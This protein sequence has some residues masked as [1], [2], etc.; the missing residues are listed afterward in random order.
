[1]KLFSLF[2]ARRYKPSWVYR[3]SG[4]LWRVLFSHGVHIA[5]EHRENEQKRVTF[6]C[7]DSR[8]GE[9]KW[10]MSREGEGWWTTTEGVY[11][12]LLYLHA[13][14]KP[15]LPH[16]KHITAVDLETGRILWEHPELTFVYATD[17]SVVAEHRSMEHTRCYRIDAESGEILETLTDRNAVEQGKTRARLNDPHTKL[18]FPERYDHG[19]DDHRVYRAYLQSLREK[20]SL[21]DPVEVFSWGNNLIF[22]YHQ[23]QGENAGGTAPLSHR[24]SIIHRSDNTLLYR[25]TILENA[26]AP[27]PD[28]FMVKDTVLYYIRNRTELVA[29]TMQDNP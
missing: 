28:G 6:F 27:V 10:S 23:L 29:I 13:F 9:E 8:T 15:D 7:L 4:H 22:C 26:S 14:A 18:Q 20:G 17:V 21:T 2:N 3:G 25:D 16:P 12:T 5:G 19:D 1:M 11:G 24:L